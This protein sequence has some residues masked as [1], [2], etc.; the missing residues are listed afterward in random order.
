[1]GKNGK[2]GV[3]GRSLGGVAASYLS[4]KVDMVITDR[5]FS[6]LSAMANWWLSSY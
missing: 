6:N 5:T 2:I 1:M 4:S 3:Y